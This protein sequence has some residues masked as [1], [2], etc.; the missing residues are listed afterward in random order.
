MDS[1]VLDNKPSTYSF[2]S[3]VQADEATGCLVVGVA[4]PA[5]DSGSG[6]LDFSNCP[7]EPDGVHEM[8]V[9]DEGVREGKDMVEVEEQRDSNIILPVL[10]VGDGPKAKMAR[11]GQASQ[12]SLVQRIH[13]SPT[14]HRDLRHQHER[15]RRS[16]HYLDLELHIAIPNPTQTSRPKSR[17]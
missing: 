9:C 8:A 1:H 3:D 4:S 10:F 15:Q 16:S 12:I 6:E 17:I 7:K 2:L 14:R 13:V 5:Q 11:S